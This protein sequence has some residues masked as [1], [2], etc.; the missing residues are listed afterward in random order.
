[1][2]LATYLLF[3]ILFYKN[4]RIRCMVF[5]TT[6]NNISAISCG[7]LYWWRKPEYPEKT[8]DLS[9]VTNKLYQMMLYRDNK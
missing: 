9:Q 1:M 6:F 2:Y 4:I 8:T 7:Q 5:T 3:V